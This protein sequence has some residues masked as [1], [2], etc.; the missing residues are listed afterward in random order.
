MI[1]KS[2]VLVAGTAAMALMLSAA[3]GG[4]SDDSD[5]GGSD[6]ATKAEFNIA[7]DKVFNPSDKKGGIIKFA[8]AGDWDTL[9]PGETYYG[10]SWNFARLYG[11]SLLT[12]KA[13]PGEA[14]NELVPDLAEDLGKPTDNGKTWTYTI[15]QGVKFEDGTEQNLV[16]AYDSFLDQF[17]TSDGQSIKAGKEVHEA[18]EA[19]DVEQEQIVKQK[20]G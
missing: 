11:R 6:S 16:A 15:K 2:K 4:G 3:C 19:D 10:Y 5:S 14:S 9:D 20:R 17:E 8:N 7:N 18:L 12:F 13:A 1:R